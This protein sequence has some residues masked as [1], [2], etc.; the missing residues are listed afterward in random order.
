MID[1][2]IQLVVKL[3][4]EIFGMLKA[5]GVSVVLFCIIWAVNKL[6]IITEIKSVDYIEFPIWGY[7][8]LTIILFFVF[9]KQIDS[10]KEK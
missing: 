1:N 7:I 9:G 4:N 5:T 6:L 10:N 3:E 8:L 2:P